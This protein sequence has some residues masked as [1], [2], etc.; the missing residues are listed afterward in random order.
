MDNVATFVSSSKLVATNGKEED[1]NKK[2]LMQ[3]F[4]AAGR[5]VLDSIIIILAGTE[6]FDSDGNSK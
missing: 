1:E 6:S 5:I 4:R 2:D 3:R